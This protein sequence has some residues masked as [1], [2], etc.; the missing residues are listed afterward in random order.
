MAELSARL[1]T[2]IDSQK[3]FVGA[4]PATPSIFESLAHLG[5]GLVHV[6]STAVDS[7]QQDAANRKAGKD[8]AAKNS[9]AVASV[10]LFSDP[11]AS[12][13]VSDV[14]TN[15]PG[16]N[17]AVSAAKTAAPQVVSQQKAAEQ[18]VLD[19]AMAQARALATVRSIMGSHP[20]HEAAVASVFREM[21]VW[22]MVTQQY[23]NAEKG[24]EDDLTAQHARVNKL[25]DDAV[26][27]YGITNFDDKKPE[28]QAKDLAWVGLQNA[29]EEDLKVKM[30]QATLASQQADL[31]DKERKAV[32]E[33]SSSTLAGS[34]TT[35]MN[36]SFQGVTK[37]LINQ[38]GDPILANDTARL[39]KL[40]NHF[41]SVALPTLDTQ[42][43]QRFAQIAPM[44]SQS[45]R[46][47]VMN[48]FKTQRQAIVDM[49]SGPQSVVEG[50]HRMMQAITDSFGIDYSKSAPTLMK[51]QKL[52]GPQA[53]GV[54][55]S[56]QVLGNPA[57][58]QMI[59]DELNGVISDPSRVPSFTEFVQTLSG[60]TDISSMDPAKVQA[61]MPAK[62]AALTAQAKDVVSTNGTDKEGHKALVNNVRDVAG[63]AID[64]V[65][66]W[67]FKS[68]LSQSKNLNAS[69]VTRSLFYTS[70]NAPERD[71]AIKSW[72]P[73]VTRSYLT[74]SG[75]KAG[76]AH[77]EAHLDPHTLQWKAVWNGSADSRK[78]PGIGGYDLTVNARPSPTSAVLEQVSTL[79]HMLNNLSVAAQMGKDQ[80]FNGKSIPY[81][82]AR[83]YFATGAIP[84]TVEN[85]SKTDKKGKTPEQNVDDAISHMLDFVNALPTAVSVPSGPMT[86]TISSTATKYNIP[87]E[88][89]G[90]LF[91]LESDS[92]KNPRDSSKGAVGPGQ[93]LPSTAR[94]YGVED[95]HALTPAQNIDLA[96][97]ILSDNYKK[98]GNWHDAVS[99]YHSGVDLATAARQHRTD[100]NM[101]TVD[102]VASIVGPTGYDWSKVTGAGYVRR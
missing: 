101:H 60:H 73:A 41:T 70:A 93:I 88:I 43:N 30:Q 5:S 102:Y 23:N 45:D 28:E 76:D 9:A 62:F 72:V 63:A 55:V 85:A 51:L 89:A 11:S 40:Q 80:T 37:M 7:L 90:R 94:A 84:A 87:P 10:Q 86:E 44:L 20:G 91:H 2:E 50:N 96:M 4:A 13:K 48:Q 34:F 71:D 42:F 75:L 12:P 83:K 69:G 65:P 21:G 78:M 53:L 68:V 67:G 77:Y 64:V 47:M 29:T 26:N 98:S 14:V 39:T 19:P 16:H 61:M 31:T 81:Q 35:L 79:N 15:D 17:A 57:M 25:R 66:Q 3:R 56:P 33:S 54:I 6:A 59:T 95:L 36:G 52:I 58:R 38:L 32:Q 74:L 100:G 92:G 97:H 1:P 18:G 82:E 22:N 99:M 27:K 8:D 24:I 46:E 49:V